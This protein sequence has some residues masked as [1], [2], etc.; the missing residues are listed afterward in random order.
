MSKFI[1]LTG[2]TFGRLTVIERAENSKSGKTQWLCKC[3]C[4]NEIIVTRDDL[5]S[6]HTKSCGCYRKEVTSK[7]SLKDLIGQTFERLTVIERAINNKNGQTQWLCKCLCGNKVTIVGY[8]LT[9]GKTKSCGCLHRETM[10]KSYGE[11]TF[12]STICNYKVKAKKRGHEFSL[13]DQEIAELMLLPCKYCGKKSSNNTIS[14]SNNGDFQYSGIDRIDNTK[15]YI[16]GN[17]A[18]SCR[19]CNF[20]KYT[21]SEDEFLSC[22][23]YIYE[24]L[25]LGKNFSTNYKLNKD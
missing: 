18:P 11:A 12:N 4:G 3:K 14:K 20:G 2:K 10:S 25:D 9:H 13:S 23:K 1:D 15:G 8:N 17:V 7:R 21:A 5:T 6:S 19:R 22:I 16:K 24:H